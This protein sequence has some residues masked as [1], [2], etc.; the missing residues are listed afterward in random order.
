MAAR[1]LYVAIIGTLGL[2]LSVVSCGAQAPDSSGS[3][4]Q[5][6]KAHQTGSAPADKRTD[7]YCAQNH[8][9]NCA[10]GTYLGPHAAPG[11][12][13]GYWDDNGN[14]VDGGP[15]GADGSTGNNVSQEYC[16][17]NE[18]PACPAGS[19]V[20][21]KAIKNPD[22][23]SSYVPCEGTIC[24]NPNH[25]GADET[26]RWDAQG[27]PVNGGPK[28]ADGSTGN[29]VSQE[30]CARNEDP[31]CPAGS[32]VGP[33]AIKNPDGS[34]SYVPCEGTIC[35]NPNHGGGDNA[36]VPGDADS[37]NPS[38]AGQDSPSGQ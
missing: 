34:S 35:T 19:Y 24:T 33:K 10:A 23:S 9:A 25:G 5:H 36:G 7:A 20:G 37:S 3:T 17:R 21:P 38:G 14:P 27:Q 22:G 11:A 26:G 4:P 1:R 12:G 13:A 30:Y 29:N 28:G 31:A 16:A 8:D 6:A 2:C 32:Y 18:D 15:V